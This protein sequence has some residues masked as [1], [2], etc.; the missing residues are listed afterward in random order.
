LT[1]SQVKLDIL[2]D[3]QEPFNNN[4]HKVA[5]DY[6]E[7]TVSLVEELTLS[8]LDMSFSDISDSSAGKASIAP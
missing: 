6:D 2:V 7:A 4:H 5:L 1:D 8:T 3:T